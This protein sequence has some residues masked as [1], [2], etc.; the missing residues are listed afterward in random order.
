MS[1]V[2]SE[3]LDGPTLQIGTAEQTFA[4][5]LDD[6]LL[7]SDRPELD[8]RIGYLTLPMKGF[9]MITSSSPSPTI[10]RARP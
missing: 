1:R 2:M 5:W 9:G 4:V 3:E 6:V 10:T 8:N 7:Y